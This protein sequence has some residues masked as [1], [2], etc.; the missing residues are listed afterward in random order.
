MS[1]SARVEGFADARPHAQPQN[2]S[3]VEPR[4]LRIN[5]ACKALSISRSSIYKAAAAGEIRLVKVAGENISSG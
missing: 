5:Q 2:Q 1:M 3:D 4:A